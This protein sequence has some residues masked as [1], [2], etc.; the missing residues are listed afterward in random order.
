V[1]TSTP[2]TPLESEDDAAGAASGPA[3]GSPAQQD[4]GTRPVVVG[5]DGSECG[6]EAVRWAAREAARRGAPLRIVH[7]ATYL[8]RSDAAT[9]SPELPRARH[10]TA[11]AYTVARR[12]EHDLTASTEVV[13]DEPIAALLQ[14]ASAGQLVVLGSSAT[15]APDEMVLAPVALRVA[16]RSPHPV[17]VV[18]RQRGNAGADRPV[19]AVLGIGDADDD[20]AVAEYAAAAAQRAGT[21]LMV[22][23]TRQ[24][25]R[26]TSSWADD[27][28]QWRERYPDLDVEQSELPGASG[29]DVLTAACPSPLLVLSTGPG[30][31][32]HRSLDA[33]HRWLLRHCTSPMA[34]VPQVH[35][36]STG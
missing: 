8:G 25:G 36:R 23:Q 22:L 20:T 5:V 30:T 18:P 9:P 16:A 35:G 12:T 1:S 3:P 4:A 31:L 10:I 29:G 19:V 14:A 34:L 24:A 11:Q 13:A 2:F 33:P 7:A 26:G 28:D 6:L 15:G 17:T 27:P 21:R 32:M